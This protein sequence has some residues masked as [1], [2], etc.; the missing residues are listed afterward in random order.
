MV[1]WTAKCGFCQLSGHTHLLEAYPSDGLPCHLCTLSR[2]LSPLGQPW[3]LSGFEVAQRVPARLSVAWSVPLLYVEMRVSYGLYFAS[4]GF[5]ISPMGSWLSWPSG[6][7]SRSIRS[8]WLL[9]VCVKE[10]LWH[11]E[12][13]TVPW[14][15]SPAALLASLGH[16]LL[17][18]KVLCAHE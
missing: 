8:G 13:H 17:I 12:H 6:M 11:L 10:Q 14:R 7:S 16:M 3:A 4:S 5:A 18:W 9:E 15:P 1:I 2:A